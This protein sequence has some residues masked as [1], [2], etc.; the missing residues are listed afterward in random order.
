M[1]SVRQTPTGKWELT[2]RS[3]LLPKRVYLTFASEGE[4]RTYGDQVERLLDAG[5]VP[6][7]LAPEPQ[8]GAPREAVAAVLRQWIRTGQPAR[9]D[10]DVLERLCV[11]LAG[12]RLDQVTYAWAEAWVVG[13]K[14]NANLAPSTVRKRIG[15]LS[16]ALDWWL[17]SHPDVSLGNPLRLLPR[18]A[19]TYTAADKAAAVAAGGQ[20]K[21]DKPRDH[22]LAGDCLAAVV[23]ALD[24][25]KRPD[26]QRPV[27]A[28]DDAEFRML[29]WL[30]YYTGVRLREAY[31]L[32]TAQ[33][34]LPSSTLRVRTS[35]QWH[36][37]EKWRNVPI[38]PPLA[39]LLSTYLPT[40]P[41]D[42]LLFSYWDGDRDERSLKK[43]TG[44]LSARFAKLFEYAGHA[45]LTEH[46]MRHEATC[47]WF[48]LRDSRGQWVFR[49]TEIDRI[50]GWEPGSEMS[51]RYASFRAEDL[52]ARLLA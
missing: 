10:Y 25:V 43:A 1:A 7:G 23:Q 34:L 9:T 33:V 40:R 46:D 4:A 2:I 5:I 35:K 8:Q 44:R 17:R 24:G 51:K 52:S 27:V 37:N 12:L 47:Q 13:M 36:D 29:F 30:I 42:G 45:E 6:A 26:R 49:E 38:R 19:A 50:M 3:K 18:G 39:A 14:R 41:A 32:T 21:T 11:E 15:S 31:T 22:R 16:R 28:P 20:A 48:E